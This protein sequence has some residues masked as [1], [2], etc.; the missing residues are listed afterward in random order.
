[1]V[2]LIAV[3]ELIAGLMA[4]IF[5]GLSVLVISIVGW[6]WPANGQVGLHVNPHD[7]NLQNKRPLGV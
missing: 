6:V 3:A 5:F 4:M 2:L 7:H 1:M